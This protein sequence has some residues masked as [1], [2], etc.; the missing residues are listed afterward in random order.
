MSL[1]PIVQV[2]PETQDAL[3]RSVFVTIRNPLT[4]PPLF[5]GLEL[6]MYACTALVLAHAVRARRRGDTWPL[7]LLASTFAYGLLIE[8]VSYNFVDN[9]THGPFTVMFYRDKL[10]LYVSVLYPVFIYTAATTVKRFGLGRAAE[11][12]AIGLL[13]VAIDFPFDIC[14]P[15][16]RWWAWSSNDPNIAYRW[17]AVPVT[18][19]YW[20]LTF[21][22]ILCMLVRA[23]S[24]FVSRKRRPLLAGLALAFP[25][26]IATMVLG[27]LAFLPFHG[28]K[29]LHVSD[30]LIVGTLLVIA[31]LVTVRAKKTVP[32]LHALGLGLGLACWYGWHA[33]V[34]I[35]LAVRGFLDAGRLVAI[36]VA[37]TIGI[38]FHLAPRL[39]A[40]AEVRSASPAE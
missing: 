23:L 25:V 34:A 12:F 27:F 19:Y 5:L 29:A 4:R 8:I 36:V 37:M 33:I 32:D 6:A 38:A 1:S 22:G 17:H 30:G 2:P 39:L 15:I 14:G 3:F 24:A 10:P 20:H 40:P 21:G 28:L 7:F 16:A 11:P 26:G 35:M 18:S 13:I 31:L 9:F